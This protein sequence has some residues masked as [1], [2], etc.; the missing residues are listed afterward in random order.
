MGL[1]CRRLREKRYINKYRCY[2]SPLSTEAHV[3][4]IFIKGDMG[5]YL[6]DIII[7]SQFHINQLSG[8]DSVRG[9][10][11]PFPTEKPGPH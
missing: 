1:T 11:L 4:L 8:F 3:E 2:I 10:N 7:Y 5:A 6:L 9:R